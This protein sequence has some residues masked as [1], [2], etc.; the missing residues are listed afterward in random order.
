[1]EIPKRRGNKWD[2]TFKGYTKDCKSCEFY[3][4]IENKELCGWG[5]AFKYLVR[6]I[7]LRKCE[8]K[9]R[10]FEYYYH[11]VKYLDEIIGEIKNG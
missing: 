4:E 11:S 6:P 3:R 8:V 5:V 10:E 7:K 1:M 2:G 9:N